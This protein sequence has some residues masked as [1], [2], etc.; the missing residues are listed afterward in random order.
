MNWIKPI[1]LSFFK[2]TPVRHS[3]IHNKKVKPSFSLEM[4]EPKILLSAE[5]VGGVIDGSVYI[6]DDGLDNFSSQVEFDQWAYQLA[7]KVNSSVLSNVQA[8]ISVQSDSTSDLTFDGIEAFF[9]EQ[10]MQSDTDGLDQLLAESALQTSSFNDQSLELII[11]DPRTPDYL[12]LVAGVSSDSDSNY[13]IYILDPDLDGVQQVTDLLAQHTG[14]DA[15]HLI[16]HGTEGSIQLGS[17]WLSTDNLNVFEEGIASW[18][19]FFD[20]NADILIYG[21]DLAGNLSGEQ[22]INSLAELT[23]ADV[24]ASTDATGDSALGGDW[25][26][27]YQVG[28]ISTSLAFSVSTQQS[29]QGTLATYVV[30]TTD[31]TIDIN[32]G[33]GLAVD[34]WGNTS[35]RAAIMEANFDAGTD[36]ITLGAGTYTLSLAG[37]D[38]NDSVSG[39][40]DVNSTIV[41]Q[42]E[43]ADNT[44]IDGDGIDRV[45][46]LTKPNSNLTLNDLSVQGGLTSGNGGGIYAFN[47]NATLT[48]NQ[49]IVSDNQAVDG[50]GI[51]NKGTMTLTDV[52]ISGNIST[53]LSSGKGGGLYNWNAATLANVTLSGNQAGIGGGIYNDYDLSLTN[54]TVSGNTAAGEEGGGIY[55]N[56]TLTLKNVTIS[57]NSAQTQGGGIY[58]PVLGVTNISN[59]IVANNTSIAGTG[60]DV[61]GTF[62]S[63]GSNLIEDAIGSLSFGGDITGIDP[64]LGALA[65]NGGFTQ[66]HAITTTSEAFNNGTS[67]GAPAEDQR[68]TAR[69]DGSPD[70]GAYEYSVTDQ[71]NTLWL[72]T[73]GSATYDDG[74]AFGSSDIVSFGGALE[75]GDGTSGTTDGTFSTTYNFPEN[76]RAMHY[77]NTAVTV[78]TLVG[79]TQGTYDLQEGQVVLSMRADDKDDFSVLTVGGGTIDVNNTDLLVYTPSETGPGGTYEFLLEDAIFKPD[80]TTPANIHAVS[81]VESDT[82]LANG[83][84]LTQGTYLIARSGNSDDSAPAP[85]VHANISTYTNLDGLD[86]LL[87]GS[88]FLSD[89]DKQIQGIEFIESATIIGGQT[90]DAGTIL[91]TVNAS[92]TVGTTGSTTVSATVTDIVALTINAT[93]Q[94]STPNT[95]V[96]AQILFDGSDIDLTVDGG[97][98]EINGLTLFSL[99]TNSVPDATNLSQT[100]AYSEGDASV[101]LDD[102]VITD[103]DTGETVT[104]SL[105]LANTAAGD[106]TSGTFG[107]AT[108][109]Y[110]SGTGIWTVT[111]SVTD[112]NDA[113]VAVAFV[114]T[115]NNDVNTTITTHIEDAAST[116]PTDGTIDLNVTAQNDDP[117][118]DNAIAD[119]NATEDSVFNFTFAADIF[120]DVDTGSTLTYSAQLVGGSV[121]PSWLSFDANT[122]T[123]SGTPL[124]ADVGSL[125]VEVIADDGMGGTP[126]TD[127]FELV[128]AN[129]NDD[130]ILNNA[131]SDQNAAEDSNFNFTFAADT[132]VDVDSGDTLIYSAQLVGGSV[133]PSWLSFDANTRTFSGTPLNADIGSLSIQVTAD[134]GQGGTPATDSFEL[135][136]ANTNDDPILNNAI[137]DQNATED[138]A[139]NFTFAADTF[140]DVDS[141]DSLTYSAQ[142]VGGS[143]LPTWLTFDASTRTFS[144]VPLNA[145]VGSLSIEVIADD[146]QGGTPA[147]DSFELVIAN[148][149]DD[150]MLEN[151]IAD[152][153]ATEDSAF[154]FTFAT[155]TFV[156]VDSGDTLTYSAQLVGGSALP[157]WLS[158][159]A[160]TRTFSGVPLNADIGSLSIQVT[161]DDS[162]GGAVATDNFELV[163]ANS[164]DDPILNNA[165]SDQN[166]TEDSNFSFTFAADTFVDVDSGDT[167]TYSAQLVGG[168]A[169]PSW[170][171]FDANTRTFSGV[172][173]NADVGSLSIQVTADDSQGGAPATDSFE[174]VIA[175][176]NDDPTLENA[177]ADQN[178][179]EDSAFNFTF[180]TDTFVDVDSGD[181]L[182]YSA[183]LVG[184]SALP[185]WLSFDANTRTFSGVPLNAD[186][187]SLSI[188]VTAD[189]DKGGTP[190]TDSFELVIANTNDD[191]ILNNA[192]SD[193]NA[194]EDSAFNFT[195]AAD[196]FVDVDSGDTLT[197]SAQLMGGSAL[198]SWLSFDANTRTFSGVPLNAD[199]GS[200]SIQVTADDSQGGT[201]ATDSFEIVIT[202]SNDDPTLNNDITEQNATEDSVFSFTF[203]TDTFNDVDSGDTLTYSAQLEGGSAL[204]T[205]LNFDASTRTFSGTPENDDVGSLTIEVIADDGQA[206]ATATF[207]LVIANSNDAPT[208]VITIN[209][210]AIEDQT[211]TADTTMLS[212]DDGLGVFSYQWLR[213]SIAISGA[214]NNSYTLDDTDV[215]SVISYQVNYTDGGGTYETVTSTDS[216]IVTNV[217]DSPTGS[218]SITGTATVGSTLTASNDL[219]DNDGLGAISYQWQRDGVD[220]TGATGINYLITVEDDNQTLKVVATYTDLNSSEE[221]VSSASTATVTGTNYAPTGSVDIIGLAQEG[222]TLTA[223]TSTLADDDGL[224]TFSYQWQRDGVNISGATGISYVLDNDDV[225]YTLKVVVTYLDTGLPFGTVESVSSNASAVVANVNG[226]ASATEMNQSKNYIE[227]D[228]NVAL[229]DIVVSDADIGDIITATLTLNDV[230]AGTLTTGT[231]AT[232]TSSYDAVTG[233]WTVTGTVND[234]NS[235]LADVAFAPSTNNDVNTSITTHIEDTLATGPVDGVIYLFVNAMNDDPTLD[236]AIADQL[237]TEDSA[238][239]FTFASDTFSDVDTG[240]SLNYTAQL[241]GGGSLPGWLSF[242]NSTRTFSG[243][244]LN[245]DVGIIN[246]KVFASDGQGG[247]IVSD[248]FNITVSNTN[249]TPSGNVTIIGSAIEDQILTADTSGITDQDGLGSFSYQWLRDGVNISAQTNNTYTLNDADVDTQISVVVSYID[250]RG[251]NESLTSVATTAVVNI[252][253]APATTNQTQVK[254]Y[255]EGDSSVAFDDIVVTDLDNSETISATLVLSEPTSGSLSTGT[256]DSSTSNYNNV[257]GV[258][259]VSGSVIDVNAALASVEFLPDAN[260]DIDVTVTTHIEDASGAGPNDGIINLMV[261]AVNDDP[262]LNNAITDQNATEDSN[263][264]FA[265]AAD[266]FADVDSG[267]TLTYSA[268]LVGGSALPSWLSF[269]ANTRTFSG[270]P[271]NADVGS[272][273]I[274]V[275]AD[276]GLGGIP[277]TDSFELL[278]TNTND[279]PTLNNAIADQ[280]ATED[281]NFSFTFA[282]DTFS[283]VDTGA[284]LTYSAQLTDGSALPSWLSFDA[285]TR[286]FSGVPL[287]ADV[288]S[289]SIEVTADD[290]LGGIPATDSF[291]LLITNTNDD[292]T[293]NNAIADQNAT[294]DSNFSFTFAT[295]TFSDVDTGATLTYSAQLTDGSALPSW[296]SFDG[297]TRTFSGTPLNTDVGSLS[298]EVIADDGLGGLPATDSFNLVIVNTNDD[299]TLN[300]AISDQSAT[301]DSVFSFTFDANTFTD[302]DSGDTL[303]YSAQ[304]VDGSALPSWLSFDADTRTFSGTP[305]NGDVGS[306]SIEVTA[307]DGLGGLPATDSFNLVIVNTNDDPTLNNAISDQSATEDSVF[308][309]TFDANT[310]TDI[311]SGD[312][313]T[314]S[315]QLV[316]GSALPSWLSFD[317]DTRTFS[318]TPLNGDVGSLSIEVTADDGLGGSPATD[319]FELVIANTNDD[320]TLNNVIADQ[321]ATEDSNFSFTFAAD[322][323]ADVDTGATLTYS[324]QLADG[325]ALP[326][327][328]SFDANTRTFS[329]TP[330]NNDVG[331]LSIQ[332]TADDSQG[333]TPATDSFELVIANSNDD[334]TLEN[335][336]TDQNA[337]ED[338]AFNFTFAADTFADVDSGDTLT[339]SAQ[340]TDGNILPSWLSFD[341]NTRTFSGMPLNADVGSLSIEVTA[342]DSQGGNVATDTF[343]LNIANSN[344]DPILN[345]AIAD[346]NA[347][348]DSNFSFAFA[349]DT[350][351]DVDSG[352]TLTY[353]AQ[354]VDGSALPSW[355]SFDTNT[356]TFSGIPLNGDVGS[357]SIQVTADDGQGGNVATD[358][359]ELN[360]ANSNDDPTLNNTIVDQNATEDSNF[361][362]TFAADTFA[363][364]D[365]GD[366]LTYSAQLTDGSVLPS[367]L[368]FDAN[369]RT[370]S[371]VPLNADVG[372]LSVEVT[373]DDSQG[374]TPA[375][376][377][378]ELVIANSNDDPTLENAITDQNATED[379]AFNFTFAADTFADVDSGDTLTYSA[380]LTDGS[381]LP[382]WLSFDANTRTFSGVPLNADV[383]SLSIEVIADDSQG[384][385]VATDTFELNIANSN[386]DPILNNAI[387]EQNAIE[388]SNFSFTF[389][390]DA[391]TDVDSDDTL[392]Y[393]AQLVGGSALPSW[394]SFDANSRTFSGTPLN[395]DVGSLSIEVTADDNQGGTVASDNFAL[396]IANSND[397]PT[398]ENAI[399]DQNATEDSVFNFTFAADTFADVDSGDTLTYS[400]QL[401]GGSALPSWLSFDANTR[402][403]SGVPLNADVG[404]LSVEV[405]ANDGQGGTPAT[406]SF[407]IVIANTNDDPTID[408][409]IV[410]QNATEDSNF[411]FAF[412]ADT[413][414]DVDSGA[415]LTYSAQL[416]GGSALPSWLSFDANTR[417]FSGVPLNADVGSL[418]IQVTADDSQGGTP[419]TDSFELVIANSNDDPTLE[420]AITDQNATEDSAFNF[421]FAVDTFSDVDNGDTLTYSAQLVG[422]SALPS[423]LSFDANT[424]TFSGV[425][426]NADVGSLSIQVIADDNQGGTVATDT[427]ELNIPNTNDDPTLNNAIVDQN[428]TEDSNFS[429]TFATDTFSDVD[430][431]DTLTYSAQLTDGSVLPSWLSFD[432]NTRTFSGVP[433]NADVGSL[434]IQVTADDNQGGT[435][436]TDNFDITIANSNDL[437]SGSVVIKGSLLEGDI[438]T[439]DTAL[440]SDDDGLGELTFQWQK[441][442]G[443]ILGATASSYV[444]Q[445][446]D[447][448]TNI[449][450]NVTYMDIRGTFESINSLPTEIPLQEELEEIQEDSETETIFIPK[451][452]EIAEEEIT[453]EV[454]IETEALEK[455]EERQPELENELVTEVDV[456]YQEQELVFEGDEI[457][458]DSQPVNRNT[459]SAVSGQE[460]LVNIIEVN[461]GLLTD[462]YRV[463]EDPLL[464]LQTNSFIRELDDMRQNLNQDIDFNKTI[465]GSSLFVSAGISA[466]YV[467]WLARSGILL[468]SV[469]S[470]LPMWRFVDPLPILS[471]AGGALDDD[472]ESL[473]S[474]VEDGSNGDDSVADNPEISDGDQDTKGNN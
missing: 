31:D 8:P 225:G 170:L 7:D 366:T 139:F 123:F 461:Q 226:V 345:N 247:T 116:G 358:T 393:S 378:F 46:H 474:I 193:Q 386:D 18:S 332:V 395:A 300:N 67:T 73:N 249:D 198:P 353:S 87:L 379:S 420:N 146:G 98:A 180:A 356:R 391:F 142:L 81:I 74:A 460:E 455:T 359:F 308:S 437:V 253:D 416:V 320:P 243:T 61:F 263:F 340:L 14:L 41:I 149:N 96:D 129:T 471:Q 296:L 51:Y 360:I 25:D 465:V 211:L 195:F 401:V 109:S 423:W 412:A 39:D 301:E 434:S 429:F 470:T 90:V 107:S 160:N 120:V 418:S 169:L 72:S 380:Q 89:P 40:L 68:G 64:N 318:G 466:G 157:S 413:F 189:D 108:S 76:I 411:S 368:S 304:L 242:N 137:S 113:L 449:S 431:G 210:S 38:E 57:N 190:A 44:I 140:A 408:N 11:I 400:A 187:G 323:F 276:D 45:F 457:D 147:T 377:S 205:W 118:I 421:T 463:Y 254:N 454:A 213:D 104:A 237:A 297:N 33:D 422:G 93:E 271:L 269:D 208:G 404:S 175:N 162:Q 54:V 244:P 134:D 273:S 337:T 206:G 236:N 396:V 178:A 136:I 151:A 42:G 117:T 94:D 122:R 167:L 227:G 280:N 19:G 417:T 231:F 436:A 261:T 459:N 232:A 207:N 59:T 361:S 344:D 130:P 382:S 99:P 191:P 398:L 133:L 339:Y 111:G 209:G 346:Q 148:T 286:T 145:D 50:S 405:I 196:T 97:A 446:N 294:E 262:T 220:I 313:L 86:D 447:L 174:L 352:A 215:G 176:T 246:I 28:D 347:T 440:I 95:D 252:N 424:R 77:V 155:A 75:L 164:N 335:A 37:T 260:N 383:G 319:N 439:A 452:V 392:T 414:A 355:L 70:I 188:Q 343:E 228:V 82:T 71:Q 239:N 221:T 194:T 9:S 15:L 435:V 29:W 315:A 387:A 453:A 105:T 53:D 469:L 101:E 222:E 32:I 284:T 62:I 229:N 241:V 388:D 430:S 216:T 328:L 12:E 6:A 288:G 173:L 132:F 185:S 3:L 331:S 285:N 92:L 202:N 83:T 85:A 251:T 88:E 55:N 282:T 305:L 102:I 372:S 128:I 199:V 204:P 131:I 224:G 432:A 23:G 49:V 127:S 289:L 154:N 384:G 390:A 181:T 66:T 370:F 450:V 311:D 348:E 357:L 444:L 306:L 258:W 325:S 336:I 317:A 322:T 219:V 36:T 234:V 448:G 270:V 184:G 125:S 168:S 283:D 326:S 248:S 277:A 52:E 445:E 17:T 264:S 468:S 158:F 310:F 279:D 274:E 171:S 373:A 407:D 259:T 290:G 456:L 267:A 364:V 316:D 186:I 84:T 438:L 91:V 153:N 143:A 26:L 47:Q 65:D 197:Y 203:A 13:L 218:V 428:T 5:L 144:G 223:D 419:A 217:N 443:D 371:G 376:D 78:D 397:D 250:A 338:S 402:T 321:N 121:L 458:V 159:D 265:F 349:A 275:T 365:S 472:D 110:D 312:T 10:A 329:G 16:S 150:P 287:N 235:A 303:T 166:A 467:A 389:A 363:D 403:F 427:F 324:A 442:G 1:L 163:I 43:D 156:D 233:I 295:D 334:P 172:P 473:E 406:D 238:F 35:L 27:E 350:F 291:E 299:P 126:A 165:I 115:T 327:W 80:G 342:D 112:V 100:Q 362:F 183:Q 106:L 152:Q 462:N 2:T 292:P 256:F 399:T 441:D 141:G 307:D 245:D 182:T 58:N 381:V 192:I 367:W 426:L 266:T 214:I 255:T 375:T 21:C 138:S 302:I 56:S 200:L 354:L 48:L 135:V 30:N 230:N 257:T 272:L 425:P 369:S 394:L 268:Q 374:G 119:Q 278:I 385:N 298:I 409:A 103:M 240:I 451:V 293:L 309:F 124:N 4:L 464:L 24:A 63:D 410:D 114:P 79:G 433:L 341:A 415:T 60:D 69:D 161:A 201:P 351:A 34:E 281:S 177:I 22:L 212:D 330:L 333:G 20:D 314:Y 179:T